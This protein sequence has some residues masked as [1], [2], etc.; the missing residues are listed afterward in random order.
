MAV[1]N[2]KISFIETLM[3]EQSTE[4]ELMKKHYYHL[5]S[6]RLKG[7]V[8][9]FNHLK[10]NVGDVYKSESHY[11][12]RRRIKTQVYKKEDFPKKLLFKESTSISIPNLDKSSYKSPHKSDYE[13]YRYRQKFTPLNLQP[14]PRSSYK[15]DFLYLKSLPEEKIVNRDHYPYC[16]ANKLRVG[17]I[18]GQDYKNT[19]AESINHRE[20]DAYKNKIK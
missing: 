11:Q 12:D 9:D 14:L 10:T 19:I 2:Q 15:R 17:S 3:A 6:N 16:P 20:L 4:G 18:Y 1:L 8:G 5:S 7:K 13:S